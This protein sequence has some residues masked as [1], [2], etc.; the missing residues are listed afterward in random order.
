MTYFFGSDTGYCGDM[1]RLTGTLYPVDFAAIP[2]GAY[3]P[4]WF[5][6][7]A[8]T[9]PKNAVDIHRDVKSKTR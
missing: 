4:R 7:P 1:F 2:I 6:A 8:H 5:M 9:D 3:H